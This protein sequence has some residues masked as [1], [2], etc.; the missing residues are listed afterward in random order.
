MK[1]PLRNWHIRCAEA[2][3]ANFWTFRQAAQELEIPLTMEEAD[4]VE[5]SREFRNVLESAR[6]RYWEELATNPSRNKEST[7]GEMIWLC[8]QL[9]REGSFDKALEGFYKIARICGWL[10]ADTNVNI[11]GKIT[12]ADIEQ[13]RK[14]LE[15]GQKGKIAPTAPIETLEVLGGIQ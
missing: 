12:Q 8:R 10:D 11:F 14:E 15:K 13:A 1:N 9:E 7:I 6:L 5:K 3:V 4:K 2:M